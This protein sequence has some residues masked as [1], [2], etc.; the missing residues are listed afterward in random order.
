MNDRSED[1]YQSLRAVDPRAVVEDAGALPQA[2]DLAVPTLVGGERRTE[3]GKP[4]GDGK[5]DR[6][7]GRE[8]WGPPR[9]E[10][11]PTTALLAALGFV[12]AFAAALAIFGLSLTPDRLLVVLLVPALV[13]RRA[14]RY[15]LDFVPFAALIVLYAELR[16]VAHLVRP[17]PYYL[18]H[19]DAEKLLF[20]GALPPVELQHWLWSGE[21]RW[22]DRLCVD[23]TRI[24]SIVPPLLA[25]ALWLK[26]RALFYRFAVTIL[27]L[28]FAAA[29][30][31]VVYP[32]APPWAAAEKGLTEPIPRLTE[33][34]SNAPASP[35]SGAG[36][37]NATVYEVIDQNPY[38]AIPSL[39]AGY[40][41]LAFLFVLTLAWRTRWRRL[42]FLGALYP[43]AQCFAAV[44]TGN[45]YV[46]D[47]LIGFAYAAAA[48]FGIRWLWRRRG[49]PE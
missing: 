27:A 22:F 15:L 30:T 47:L 36:A 19:L 23:V 16:G 32:S 45:H 35:T 6:D 28:S 39:H 43:L 17:H 38:A 12:L 18:P 21:L 34:R 49:L 1:E 44:Y 9:T 33:L 29:I 26:R 31:F 3:E 7:R 20:G 25:F 11:D 40:A 42:A 10:L 46:I 8:R 24:H 41:F 37:S 14:R 13:L 5:E 2:R 4:R 48:L